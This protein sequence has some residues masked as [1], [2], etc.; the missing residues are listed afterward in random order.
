MAYKA[1]RNR[2]AADLT[3]HVQV[4]PKNAKVVTF[5]NKAA[6]ELRERLKAHVGPSADL[7]VASTFH[8]LCM[9]ILCG[10]TTRISKSAYPNATGGVR[11]LCGYILRPVPVYQQLY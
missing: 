7:V 1:H 2:Y 6:A 9:S 3:F 5:T 4:P 10:D 11:L 8:T